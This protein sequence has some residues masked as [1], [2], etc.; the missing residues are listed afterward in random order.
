MQQV[1]CHAVS[2]LSWHMRLSDRLLGTAQ[3]ELP[4][5]PT[6]PFS[7]S[8]HPA[9]NRVRNASSS[10]WCWQ[11]FSFCE[12]VFSSLSGGAQQVIYWLASAINSISR[13]EV[14]VLDS[15][16]S[17]GLCACVRTDGVVIKYRDSSVQ[18]NGDRIPEQQLQP[19]LVRAGDNV[20]HA[21]GSIWQVLQPLVCIW[22]G[23]P[24]ILA[25]KVGI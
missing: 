11:L 9:E 5:R 18:Q 25:Q 13:D 23:K 21:D 16:D 15:T 4:V 24:A 12:V 19:A 8:F 6:Y 20:K 2:C 17:G 14:F 3:P 1:H 7:D 22:N 10:A